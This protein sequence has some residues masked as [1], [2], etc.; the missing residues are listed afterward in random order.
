MKR[1]VVLFTAFLGA[2]FITAG[3]TNPRPEESSDQASLASQS[4]AAIDGFKN[5]D[6]TLKDL[7]AKSVGY[8]IFPEVGKAGFIA[9]GSYGKGEV[10]EGGKKIGHA[11]I[12]QA[13]V[14]LQAGA[15]TF[16]ELI[17]FIRQE[18]LTKFKESQ[19]ALAGNISAVAIKAGAAGTADTSKGVVV[20]V[21]S[22]GGLMAEAAVGGQRFR[23]RP[24]DA[25]STEAAAK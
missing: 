6:P 14:G 15:Q 8:A 19:F 7:L 10:F 20:F 18:E 16:N 3:C 17:I 5:D 9:G 13:T 4:S 21:R 11:D 23:F 12:S 24:L 25:A 1:F 22:T 2:A